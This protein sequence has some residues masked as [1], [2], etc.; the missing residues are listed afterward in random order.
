MTTKVQALTIKRNRLQEQLAMWAENE[1]RVGRTWSILDAPAWP[2]FEENEK[3][4][5]AALNEKPAANHSDGPYRS[6]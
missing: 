2:W 5:Q 3:E 4:L 1:S 6:G